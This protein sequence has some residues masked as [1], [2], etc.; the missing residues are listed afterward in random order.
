MFRFLGSIDL[1]TEMYFL[2]CK[3]NRHLK[4]NTDYKHQ[5]SLQLVDDGQCH[6]VP[7]TQMKSLEY[8]LIF[9]PLLSDLIAHLLANQPEFC[10]QL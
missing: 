3:S 9:F 1:I 7:D 4:K 5:L 2:F 8:L 10:P 6:F